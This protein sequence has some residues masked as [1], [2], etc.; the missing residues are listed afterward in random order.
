MINAGN[1]YAAPYADFITNMDL[2]GSEYTIIDYIVP[3]YQ[4]ALHG[5][6]DYSGYPVNTSGNTDESILNA[7]AYGAGLS[8]SLMKESPFTLQ[9]TLY[10]EYYASDYD[11]WK[12]KIFDIYNRFNSEL[13]H[14]YGQTIEGFERLSAD[15][16][17]TVYADG[18]EVY[19][20][21]G[22]YDFDASGITIPA[23][24]YKVVR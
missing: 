10:T 22:Y 15:V 21:Y 17:K 19:V 5:Y 8:F 3:F 1:A 14:T 2:R 7:A 11:V 16:S 6:V 13:G 9:K 4:I 18:T 24:D 12:D 23:R 20:N